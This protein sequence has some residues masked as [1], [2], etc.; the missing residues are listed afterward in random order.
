MIKKINL[1]KIVTFL[2]LFL[3]VAIFQG[4]EKTSCLSVKELA[5]VIEDIK[6]LNKEEPLW[7]QQLA[8]VDPLLL[9]ERKYD[10]LLR[11]WRVSIFFD[12]I[13]KKH[14]RGMTTQ[15]V[16][17]ETAKRLEIETVKALVDTLTVPYK[18]RLKADVTCGWGHGEWRPRSLSYFYSQRW[19]LIS[20]N[21]TVCIISE[22]LEK[23]NADPEKILGMSGKE[24][25]QLAI[26]AAKR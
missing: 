10:A 21:I 13:P 9:A 1:I 17:N 23:M 4:C 16:V 11:A 25:R 7:K 12:D 5:E 15:G 22:L 19:D 14:L 3:A 6:K 18:E 26:K 2:F 20:S 24:L 8:G